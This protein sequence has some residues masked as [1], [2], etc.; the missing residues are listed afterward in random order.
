VKAPVYFERGAYPYE[1]AIGI[2]LNIAS[3]YG[4]SPVEVFKAI[5]GKRLKF[6][7]D[8]LYVNNTPELLPKNK[9]HSRVEHFPSAFRS[10]RFDTKKRRIRFC[11]DCMR[12]GYH[13]VFFCL[14]QVEI[15]LIH[16]RE[17]EE[18]CGACYQKFSNLHAPIEACDDCGFYLGKAIE[19]LSSRADHA[20]IYRLYDAGLAQQKWFDFIVTRA[21]DGE[22][23]FRMLD[24]TDSYQAT[25]S[26]AA[27]T[28]RFKL[29]PYRTSEANALNR[30]LRCL[31]WMFPSEEDSDLNWFTA[32]D[33]L[34]QT[35]LGY[36]E[37]CLRL[38]DGYLRYWGGKVDS[39]EVCLMSL[40]YFFVRLRLSSLTLQQGH[41]SK[42]DSLSF[43]YVRALENSF[44]GFRFIPSELIRVYFLKLLFHIHFY[45]RTGYIVRI[46]MQPW[47]GVFYDLVARSMKN[48]T[49]SE[50]YLGIVPLS[51]R[52][53]TAALSGDNG[54][55]VEE[56]QFSRL[57]DHHFIIKQE[58]AHGEEVVEV[59]I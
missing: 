12:I 33:R 51:Q 58:S 56:C 23:F 53:C 59:F 5:S 32:C 48:N 29:F 22:S 8:L 13:S 20:L 47:K 27:L 34:V 28:V 50:T 37:E 35:H 46:A 41:A 52:S 55:I 24:A 11:R 25:P 43:D 54:L 1:S 7:E 15:C 4:S 42:L 19:Q 49:M 44:A 2:L 16:G 45:L 9:L 17:L 6:P 36:H 30:S 21:R 18:L 31:R 14:P 57:G 38:Y 10:V 26:L 40:V 39:D 3:I